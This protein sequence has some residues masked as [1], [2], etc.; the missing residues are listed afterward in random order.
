[1]FKI[2]KFNLTPPAALVIEAHLDPQVFLELMAKMVY[3]ESVV[4]KVKLDAPHP[5]DPTHELSFQINAHAKLLLDLQVVQDPE[6][7]MVNLVMM[8]PQETTANQVIKVYVVLQAHPVNLDALETK[9]ALAPQ[10][11]FDQP[12]QLHLADLESLDAQ[13][14]LVTLAD[15]ETQVMM[16]PQVS[17]APLV[18][19]E[20]LVSLDEMEML[21]ALE[22]RDHLAHLAPAIN[23]HQLDWLQDIKFTNMA[24]NDQENLQKNCLQYLLF[25]NFI[26]IFF[27][28][29]KCFLFL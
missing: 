17:L 26:G 9:D 21:D 23:A 22:L 20:Q 16:E 15:Q 18:I 5:Q 24:D 25:A 27:L 12:I 10:D 11:N 28:R 13:V 6:V 8:E 3:Q 2:S 19:W 14:H 4:V 7:P 1:M 29:T